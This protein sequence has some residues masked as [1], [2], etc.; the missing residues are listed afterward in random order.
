MISVTQKEK[1][2]FSLLRLFI[3]STYPLE[4][5]L[6]SI[7]KSLRD[8]LRGYQASLF[9]HF[10][11]PEQ[12]TFCLLATKEQI[13]GEWKREMWQHVAPKTYALYFFHW[14]YSK[15]SSTVSSKTHHAPNNG[16]ETLRY[17]EFDVLLF[18][19]AICTIVIGQ[20]GLAVCVFSQKISQVC[21]LVNWEST[22]PLGCGPNTMDGGKKT[23]R[24]KWL[25]TRSLRWN[26]QFH[27]ALEDPVWDATKVDRLKL[28]GCR[29]REVYC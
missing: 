28:A 18:W 19:G 7:T 16:F 4:N 3:K 29:E 11:S 6:H 13:Y 14:A 15:F 2:I 20:L 24:K 9:P 10:S 22:S 5:I 8:Q 17:F 12:K 26:H 21:V 27:M 25:S 1:L 23:S